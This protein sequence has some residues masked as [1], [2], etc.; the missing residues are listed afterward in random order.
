MS[1]EIEYKVEIPLFTEE[2]STIWKDIPN[3]ISGIVARKQSAIEQFNKLDTAVNGG[4]L[5]QVGIAFGEPIY[6]RIKTNDPDYAE[7]ITKRLSLL[8]G[9]F[10]A[11]EPE[12]IILDGKKY[13]VVLKDEL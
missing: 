11:G 6:A 12:E 5:K 1:K 3:V 4:M 9:N 7:Y 2:A 13:T 8:M 10:M